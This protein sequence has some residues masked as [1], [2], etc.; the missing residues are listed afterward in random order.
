[1]KSR[2]AKPAVRPIRAGLAI[3]LLLTLPLAAQAASTPQAAYAELCGPDGKASAATCAALRQELK[4]SIA[5]AQ[6]A[7]KPQARSD[8]A[9]TPS[10]AEA[11][12]GYLGV[13]LAPGDVA[14]TSIIGVVIPGSPAEASG[15]RVDDIITSIGTSEKPRRG[16]TGGYSAVMAF[17]STRAAGD[18]VTV[19]YLR[20]GAPAHVRLTLGAKQDA[21]SLAAPTGAWNGQANAVSGGS[22][23]ADLASDYI[24]PLLNRAFAYVD[25]TNV[26]TIMTFEWEPITRVFKIIQTIPG[27]AVN[28][29]ELRVAAD[30]SFQGHWLIAGSKLKASGRVGPNGLELAPYKIGWGH[31][32]TRSRYAIS[33]AGDLTVT[34][35]SSHRKDGPWSETTAM[36]S[37]LSTAQ[38]AQLM[39]GFQQAGYTLGQT[40][41]RQLDE[42]E[43]QKKRERSEFLGLL[44]QGAVAAG[45]G[46]VAGMQEANDANARSQAII[47]AAAESDRQYRAAQQ[48]AELAQRAVSNQTPSQPVQQARV[49]ANRLA[50]RTVEPSRPPQPAKPAGQASPMPGTAS[51]RPSGGAANVRPV[52]ASEGATWY[53]GVTLCEK[54]GPQAK[55]GN[56]RCTG[57]QVMDYIN[58]DKPGWSQQL[59]GTCGGDAG[60]RDYGTSGAYRVFG[61]GFPLEPSSTYDIAKRFGV[62][63][64]R[65]TWKCPTGRASC[66]RY[67]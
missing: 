22:L 66:V 36:Y 3:S 12:P 7:A 16:A 6:S 62:F 40:V 17:L 26:A 57:P 27:V 41:S 54:S 15:L 44:M 64:E 49:D 46:Y 9:E 34:A 58:F 43:A 56:W 29:H 35:G 61:C 67:Y 38:L 11:T 23:E 33:H 37:A 39:P 48:A 53:E 13:R 47:D 21:V 14:E 30:G 1:M 10:T 63:V 32:W 25:N 28:T 52:S 31:G 2:T 55:F 50:T 51:G 45:Q 18:E 8:L 20:N 42:K 60:V 19:G 65:S 4:G 59:K 24:K 5:T